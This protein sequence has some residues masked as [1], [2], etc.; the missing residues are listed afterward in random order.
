MDKHRTN[1]KNEARAVGSATTMQE[2]TKARPTRDTQL[3]LARMALAQQTTSWMDLTA[4]PG[5]Q[6]AFNFLNYR[7][8]KLTKRIGYQKAVFHV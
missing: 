6:E 2:K 3:R 1:Q 8:I 5:S 4:V 7:I